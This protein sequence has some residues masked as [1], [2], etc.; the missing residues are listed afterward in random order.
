MRKQP[1]YINIIAWALIGF[2]FTLTLALN[3]PC[4]DWAAKQSTDPAQCE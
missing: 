2:F 1:D 4:S 3:N